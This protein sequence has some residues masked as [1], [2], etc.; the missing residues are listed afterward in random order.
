VQRS[1]DAA[2]ENAKNNREFAKKTFND[3]LWAMIVIQAEAV[4]RLVVFSTAVAEQP[5]AEV[6]HDP[7]PA[8][9]TRKKSP[10]RKVT[11]LLSLPNLPEEG[12]GF[13]ETYVSSVDS[14]L[15]VNK[16]GV[17]PCSRPFE[18]EA[19]KDRDLL[20]PSVLLALADSHDVSLS[21]VLSVRNEGAKCKW[22]LL[23]M[24]LPFHVEQTPIPQY[25]DT[26]IGGNGLVPNPEQDRRLREYMCLVN[27]SLTS[28]SDDGFS[29]KRVYM[30]V[31]K[32][33]AHKRILCG[34]LMMT[35]AA[36]TPSSTSSA[37]TGLRGRKSRIS[38]P[39]KAL[40]EVSAT[41][42]AIFRQ[43]DKRLFSSRPTTLM[44]ISSCPT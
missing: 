42:C 25:Y 20:Y 11:P 44:R 6:V 21:S 4:R 39:D 35:K 1:L 22:R 2:A 12:A 37:V 13:I 28:G 33:N 36:F 43:Y 27:G 18:P 15:V 32:H 16:P 5:D 9:S 38:V 8:A 40:E 31:F 41:V 34:L 7:D 30:T 3:D 24:I 26:F 23:R 10:S 29:Y 14:H 17:Q 19:K